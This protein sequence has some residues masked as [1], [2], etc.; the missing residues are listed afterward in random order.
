MKKMIVAI[1]AICLAVVAS[2]ATTDWKLTSSQMYGKSG[3]LFTGKF[4]L[5]ASGGDLAADTLIHT[6]DSVSGGSVKGV[7]V[8]TSALSVDNTYTLWY[9]LTDSD[10]ST[11]KSATKDVDAVGTGAATVNWGNQSTYTQTAG[12]WAAVPEPT[13]ALLMVLGIAGLALKRKRA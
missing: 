1:A 5:W 2:A 4:E 11:L 3:S 13:S 6:I 12:N 9:V 7:T 8:S 10:G